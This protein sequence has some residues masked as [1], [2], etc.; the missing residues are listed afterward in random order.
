M[1]DAVDDLGFAALDERGLL[2]GTRVEGSVE[3]L[4]QLEGFGGELRLLFLYQ[5]HE[6]WPVHATSGYPQSS[7]GISFTSLLL[8]AE[9]RLNLSC[10]CARSLH[11]PIGNPPIY[12][13]HRLRQNGKRH[14]PRLRAATG[15][16]RFSG[17]HHHRG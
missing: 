2:F 10:V 8:Y 7:A 5:F 11:V 1:F 13:P 17:A 4:P 12:S 3:L 14:T 9:S 6:R 16:A 15:P